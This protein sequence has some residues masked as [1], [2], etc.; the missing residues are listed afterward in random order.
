MA[1]SKAEEIEKAES[2]R[3]QGHHHRQ[4]QEGRPGSIR[5]LNPQPLPPKEK[6]KRKKE[7]GC[8]VTETGLAHPSAGIWLPV[9]ELTPTPRPRAAFLSSNPPRSKPGECARSRRVRA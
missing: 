7:K 8:Q 4:R 1:K 3:H 9:R 2:F 6:T 5:A